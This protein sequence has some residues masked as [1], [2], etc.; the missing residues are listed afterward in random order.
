M[1]KNNDSLVLLLRY[2]RHTFLLTGDAEKQVENELTSREIHADVLKVG[3]HGS[4][5][6]SMPTFLDA[7]HPSFGIISD[8]YENSYG[9]PAPLTLE[10]LTERHIEP[11]RTDELG[12]ITVRSNGRHLEVKYK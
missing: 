7:V 3:H 2:G 1:A 4:K 12:L 6:S 9:H 11:L 8:G 10:H 5:T